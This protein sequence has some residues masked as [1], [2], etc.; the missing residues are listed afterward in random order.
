[1]SWYKKAKNIDISL[2]GNEAPV[3]DYLLKIIEIKKQMT[4]P[5]GYYYKGTEDFLLQEGQRFSS[6][7]LTEQEMEYL[8]KLI[9]KTCQ[10]KMKQCFYNA[11]S[12]AITAF[13]KIKYVEGYLYSGILPLEHAFNTINGKVIDF[14]MSH[15]NNGKPILGEIPSGWEY[16]GVTLPTPSVSKYWSTHGISEP[17]ITNWREGFPYLK[18]KYEDKEISEETSKELEKQKELKHE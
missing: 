8:K 11:Q 2:K 14:T 18:K 4:P 10:Y 9:H 1:M 15:V 5:E 16:F 13:G 12:L 3:E 6:Q 7:T 17:L